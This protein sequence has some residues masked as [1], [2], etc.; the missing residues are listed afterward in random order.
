MFNSP[1][2]NLSVVAD[3]DLSEIEWRAKFL[4]T[5]TNRKRKF[6]CVAVKNENELRYSEYLISYFIDG[7]WEMIKS[8]TETY[9][10]A[11]LESYEKH[12]RDLNVSPPKLQVKHMV[13]K[14][15]ATMVVVFRSFKEIASPDVILFHAYYRKNS[16]KPSRI[17]L[18]RSVLKRFK[19][20]IHENGYAVYETEKLTTIDEPETGVIFY[21][22]KQTPVLQEQFIKENTKAL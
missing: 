10:P 19:S 1:F 18:Y 14:I 21:I 20:E 4:E 11:L 9:S 2:E 3:S 16:G 8:E 22:V 5:E 13:S 6:R 17:N 15:L 7:E 12:Y